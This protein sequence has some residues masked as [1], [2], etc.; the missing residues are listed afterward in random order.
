V[1]KHVSALKGGRLAR[2]AAP[3]TSVGFLFSDVAGNDPA[4]IAS[5]PI[6]PDS[7]TFA[8]ALGVLDAYDVDAPASVYEHLQAGAAGDVAESPIADDTLFESVAVHILAN[9][10]TALSAADVCKRAGID[11]LIFSLSTWRRPR[12][13]QDSRCRRGGGTRDWKPGRT[14]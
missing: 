7:T 9:G 14:A 12:G 10:F 5:G 1:R 8:D 6:S 4:V 2:A 3:A 11:P 13:S